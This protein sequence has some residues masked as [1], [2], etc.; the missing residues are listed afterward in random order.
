MKS[1]DRLRMAEAS[2]PHPLLILHLL[3][4]NRHGEDRGKL[5]RHASGQHGRCG[6]GN[7]NRAGMEGKGR[8]SVYGFWQLHQ[9]LRP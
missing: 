9:D 4:R 5:E 3:L 7:G 2:A 6:L 1:A 8:V